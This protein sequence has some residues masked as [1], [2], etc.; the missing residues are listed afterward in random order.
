[1]SFAWQPG[2]WTIQERASDI[3][4]ETS[5]VGFLRIH[6]TAPI[7]GGQLTISDDEVVMNF[8]VAINEVRTSSHI[9]DPEVRSLVNG[10]SDGILRFSGQGRTAPAAV[11]LI[12]KSQAG[13]VVVD[14]ALKATPHDDAHRPAL[15]VAG[16]SH[17]E[18]IHLPLPG[19]GDIRRITVTI[20]GLLD[21]QSV[22]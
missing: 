14:L 2:E 3:S 9:L 6:A 22:S 16:E 21:L 19:L 10:H 18:N 11:D 1:M 20:T 7:T 8:G 15:A 4:I 13:D 17:F 5:R 12:G